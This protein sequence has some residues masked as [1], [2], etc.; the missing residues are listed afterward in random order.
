MAGELVLITGATGM[1]GFRTLVFLLEAGYKVRAA[2]RNQA[3][4][5]KISQLKPVAPYASQLTSIIV[6]DITVPGAY[7]EA[8]KGVEY[9]VHVASPLASNTPSGVDYDSYIIQPAIQGTVGI[10]ES[11][12]K[13]TG[14]KKLVIT[15]SILSLVTQDG[16][17][18]G[19]LINEETRTSIDNGPFANILHAYAASKS[20][21]F[22][23]TKEFIAERNP[24]FAVNHIFPVFVLGRDDTVSTAEQ[25]VKGT[26]NMLMGPLLGTERPPIPGPSVHVDDVARLHVLALDPKV[27]GNQDFLAASHPFE[28]FN[29]SDSIN[30]IKKHFPQAVAE[31]VFDQSV[32]D[33]LVSIKG[34]IDSTKAEKVFGFKF[35]TFEEQVQ[36]VVGHY[37]ELLGKN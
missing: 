23:K 33:K 29:W 3:G 11:A 22:N 5:D 21:A 6:P 13:T 1:I 27:E 4:F 26:N 12:N 7:D 24:S 10:L 16:F 25:I 19:H 37:L 2:V 34:I 15:G 32:V 30:I 18:S 14:V 9:I 36:S 17:R 8:V 28:P 31:G 35:K 20:A